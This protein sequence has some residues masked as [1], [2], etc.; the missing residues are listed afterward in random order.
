MK[1]G[2]LS[3]D[4]IIATVS[5]DDNIKIL[6][7]INMLEHNKAVLYYL[8]EDLKYNPKTYKKYRARFYEIKEE[9]KEFFVCMDIETM[10]RT[11]DILQNSYRRDSQLFEYF[12]QNAAEWIEEKEV[13]GDSML[14]PYK[15]NS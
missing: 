7:F 15:N 2:A 11:Y 10:K 1:E 6:E 14:W 12:L 5:G 3:Y 13:R 9:I 8:V 4:P